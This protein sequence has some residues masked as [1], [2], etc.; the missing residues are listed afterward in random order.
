MCDGPDDSL[1]PD[2]LASRSAADGHAGQAKLRQRVTGGGPSQYQNGQVFDQN[3]E[4]GQQV[5]RGTTITIYVQNAA[6]PTPPNGTSSSGLSSPPP[7]GGQTS[8]PTPNPGSS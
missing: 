1:W 4:P 7:S 5:A 2:W 8:S 6:S 3:P